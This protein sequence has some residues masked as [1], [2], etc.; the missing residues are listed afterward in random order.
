MSP[1]AL[2]NE[3]AALG[4]FPVLP[5][6]APCD[7]AGGIAGGNKELSVASGSVDVV[8]EL[9]IGGV[10]VT[11]TA[12]ELNYVDGVTSNVQTQ[13]DDANTAIGLRALAADSVLTGLTEAKGILNVGNDGLGS[14]YYLKIQRNGNTQLDLLARNIPSG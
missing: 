2:L 8:N 7:V 9:K 13:I 5:A 12:A 3:L 6:F 4:V 10:A 14:G 11:A 1:A